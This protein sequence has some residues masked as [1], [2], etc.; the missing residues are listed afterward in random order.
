M[1]LHATIKIC[2]A[3]TTSTE[4]KHRK[5]ARA[6][7]NLQVMRDKDSEMG[8]VTVSAMHLAMNRL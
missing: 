5:N 1:L 2:A 3:D 8:E 6:I 7:N 4:V